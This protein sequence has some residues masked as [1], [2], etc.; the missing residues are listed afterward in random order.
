[1]SAKISLVVA[2]CIGIRDLVRQGID[3]TS[4]Y[5]LLNLALDDPAPEVASLAAKVLRPFNRLP[6]DSSAGGP[7]VGQVAARILEKEATG[8]VYD[9][10]FRPID[11]AVREIEETL[12]ERSRVTD[13]SG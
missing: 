7:T 8:H 3:L 5:T 1:M 13:G 10:Q 9:I 4:L 12:N 11:K 2:A 6:S